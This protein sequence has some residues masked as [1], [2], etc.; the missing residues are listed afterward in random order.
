MVL[1]LYT[2]VSRV[3][4][5]V[6]SCPELVRLGLDERDRERFT[7]KEM[8]TIERGLS[9]MAKSQV[10][11]ELHQVSSR[12][13]E[14]VLKKYDLSTEQEQAF[15]YITEARGLACVVG[16]AGTGKSYMLR[17]AK[18]AWERE[19][20][21]T[22][23][24]T[25]SGIAAESLEEASGIR[26][27]TVASRLMSWDNNNNKLNSRDVVVVDEA[28]MLGSRD[29]A[30]VMTEVRDAGAKVVLIGDPE[31]L[32]PIQA[33]GAFRMIAGQSDF[34]QI[35]DIKR[36]NIGWQKEATLYLATGETAKA[37]EAYKK[38][39]NIHSFETREEAMLAMIEGW[40]EEIIW[41]KSQIMMA[42]TRKD[43]EKLNLEA[44]KVMAGQGM[45]SQAWKV[46][47]AKGE[48]EFAQGEKIY[49][50]RNDKYTGVKNG[51]IGTIKDMRDDRMTVKLDK[52]EVSF[53]IKEYNHI[54]YGYAATVYKAQGIT[55]DKAHVLASPNYNRHAIYVAM[56]RHKEEVQLYWAKEDFSSF[57]SLKNR[58]G[59]AGQKDVSLDY[60]DVATKFAA[61]RGI[62][63][64]FTDIAESFKGTPEKR[65]ESGKMAAIEARLE[66]RYNERIFNRDME[67]LK[68]R[69]GKEPGFE[70]KPGETGRYLGITRVGKERYGVIEQKHAIK[71]VDSKLCEDLV[72]GM[73]VGIKVNEKNREITKVEKIQSMQK[74]RDFS[75]EM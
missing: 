63:A 43:V 56:S 52:K 69:F 74:I 28:G 44:R 16:F 17:A 38:H 35:N 45:L 13:K 19:G 21:R 39:E 11:E 70:M 59:K 64:D 57:E 2:E 72:K 47:T 7:T 24:M 73:D 58:M 50:L 32:Q 6:K 3:Y 5:R 75:I 65:Y 61:A 41:N 60:I 33:G 27:Y 40:K 29:M 8:L 36:Q 51:T 49:F 14:E 48:R 18:E 30:K 34:V 31:Q 53:S 25:L 66:A 71:L 10:E 20:Y 4:E 1:H 23:G 26:S 67:A 55:V 54:D 15:R 22:L 9:V 42:Y 68:E 12:I 37:L 62:E 46:E